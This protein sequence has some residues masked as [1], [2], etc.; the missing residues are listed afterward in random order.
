M[1]NIEQNFNLND[2]EKDFFQFEKQ[3]AED[4]V[5]TLKTVGMSTVDLARAKT[6]NEGGFNNI[7][8]ALRSSIGCAISDPTG[9][10]I[11]TYF[12]PLSKGAEGSAAGIS[13]A[14]EI[15][16]LLFDG[17]YLL[18]LVA[19]QSYAALLENKDIDVISGSLSSFQK[20]LELLL[21]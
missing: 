11:F 10:V 13:Y 7:T 2:I 14:H 8:W 16:R 19:G 3:A 12:P 17:D 1:L 20:E 4:L 18:I 5:K 9:N 6:K 21:R 15:S